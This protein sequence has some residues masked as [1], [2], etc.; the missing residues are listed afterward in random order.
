MG[1]DPG[2]SGAG[3]IDRP[4]CH[5]RQ[6]S[7]KA[8]SGPTLTCRRLTSSGLAKRPLGA[9]SGEAGAGSGA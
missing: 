4:T 1:H 3:V 2:E 7:T 9:E 8:G 5:P 6:P